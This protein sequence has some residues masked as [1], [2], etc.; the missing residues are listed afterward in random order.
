M[1]RKTI[2]VLILLIFSIPGFAGEQNQPKKD[3]KALQIQICKGK[4]CYGLGKSPYVLIPFFYDSTQ[5]ELRE[6]YFKPNLGIK[7]ATLA[8][9]TDE[10]FD[11]F[12][13]TQSDK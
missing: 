8:D 4:E 2:I 5:K 13:M 3:I 9:L 10:G 7:V 11:A 12:V 1:K 6:R